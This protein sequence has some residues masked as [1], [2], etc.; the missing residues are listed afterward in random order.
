M[1]LEL[2]KRLLIEDVNLPKN[3]VWFHA[4]S[5]GEFNSVK[6]IIEYIS[7][8]FPVFITY[9]SPRAKRFFL[10]LDYPT[11]P[12]PLDLPII[13]NKFIANAKPCC[14]IT[15]EKEFWPFLIKSD[16]PKML[17]N[18]R[19]P[20]NMLERFLIRFFDK[21]LPK[22]ENSFELLS[23]INK[24]MVL[25]GN[26][27]LCI[28]VNCEPI[29]KDSI[30]IGSTHEKEEE[31]LL[32]A[33]KWIIKSTDYNVILAPRHIDRASE[34]LKLLRQN[35]IDA[36][37]KTQKKY[38]RVVVLDTLGEL[39]E[40]YKRAIVSIVGGSFVKGYGGHNIVEPVG[41]CSYS[42][43]GEHVDKIKDVATI[44]EKMGIG[45]R[46]EKKSVLD[47]VKLC[48]QNPLSID[49][50]TKF[51]DYTNSIKA[52]YLKN[53]EAFVLQHQNLKN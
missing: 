37:L 9:F 40:Y 8:K 19:A 45:F 50:L 46:V 42:I 33:V 30:V 20:K 12:L 18:A 4:A 24:N 21:I 29:K 41:F 36:Y 31:I 43:Y 23:A 52:C 3:A 34:V 38:S 44:L 26:L 7:S 16:I 14:L 11:L 2:S 27:K 28:D 1:T 35:S 32:D 51:I 49:K 39:K 17:L 5:I 6:F 25:C 47:T 53:V 22:D 13:W 48:L 15:V 10:N